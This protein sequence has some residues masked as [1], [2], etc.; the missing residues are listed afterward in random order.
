[1]FLCYILHYILYAGYEKKWL[2]KPVLFGIKVSRVCLHKS[3]NLR[4]TFWLFST[5]R[6]PIIL[7]LTFMFSKYVDMNCLGW[8]HIWYW[9]F[10]HCCFSRYLLNLPR[11]V[12]YL[13][14]RC[15][16]VS[17]QTPM[18]Y[19]FLLWSHIQIICYSFCCTAFYSLK[20]VECSSS[21]NSWYF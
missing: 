4:V 11:I 3:N 8:C 2:Q 16:F 10:W 17:C 9:T 20:C 5:S 19:R 15:L 18:G 7:S 14:I 1:M 6:W 13:A 21:D 12:R